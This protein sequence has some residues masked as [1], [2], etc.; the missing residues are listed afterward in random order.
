MPCAQRDR[1]M[2]PR[3]H[4][5]ALYSFVLAA[6]TAGWLVSSLSGGGAFPPV[7]VVL[8]LIGICLF[9][10]QFGI[11]V[12]R[13][14]LSSMERVPQVGMLL[15]LEPAG[16]GGDLRHGLAGLASAQQ[17]VQPRVDARR[18]AARRPQRR[19]DGPDAA[20]GRRGVP[21]GRRPPPARRADA[22]GHRSAG[23]DDGHGAGR[24]CG[25]AC[26]V[27]PARWPGSPPHHS[28]RVHAG[29]PDLRTRRR[30]RRGAVQ[31]R[32]ARH[33]RTVRGPDGAV[34]ALLQRIRQH[35]AHRGCRERHAC[36]TARFTAV[37]ARRAADRRARRTHSLRGACAA[38][39]RR[40]LARDR[41]QRAQD[42]RSARAGARRRT[43][44]GPATGAGLRPIRLGGGAR[45]SRARR[46]L[47]TGAGIPARRRRSRGHHPRVD[48]PGSARGRRTSHRRRRRAPLESGRLLRCGPAPDATACRAGGAGRVG[49]G[50]LRGPRALPPA[51]GATRGRAHAGAR[52]SQPG[53]G[54]PDRRA[55][56]AQPR[57]G[58]RV[59]GGPADRHPESPRLRPPARRRD[60]RGSR[61]GP[62]AGARSGGPRQLQDRQ[63]PD[64]TSRGRR[65]TA[66]QRDNHAAELPAGRP[67]GAHRR[68]GVRAH[69]A[70]SGSRAPRRCV[71]RRCAARS[72]CIPG[73]RSIPG[74]E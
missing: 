45:R 28:T 62:A 20:A 60:R 32:G 21:G 30:A 2:T 5:L 11:P 68:R 15:V 12:P 22:R 14:G 6:I 74:C 63:R 55:R 57:A 56:R 36:R 7:W 8:L 9:V 37:A 34:R 40:V 67:R 39:L 19:D 17:A 31:H 64:G 3:Y 66:A 16:R 4:W 41:G 50:R 73:P 54:A 38:A 42:P 52:S 13:V 24:E 27:L 71:A 29:G 72:S 10:W 49:R 26:S 33:L 70:G 59:A 18:R 51:P 44:A 23:R 46:G 35:A 48:D 53:E 65:G 25:A 61:H 69:P 1:G 47:G 43:P 58:T